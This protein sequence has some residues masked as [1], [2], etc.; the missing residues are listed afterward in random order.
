VVQGVLDAS[1]PMRPLFLLPLLALFAVAGCAADVDAEDDPVRAGEEP[2]VTERQLT[3]SELPDKTIALTFDDGPGPRTAEL[4]DWLASHGI[5]AAFFINGRNVP[6]RQKMVDEVI[7]KGH[8][9]GNHTQNHLDLTTLSRAKVIDEVEE[10]DADIKKVQPNGPWVLRAPFGAWNGMVTREV[11][12]TAMKKYVGS[13]FWDMGGELT[14][15]SAADWDCWGKGLT[16]ARCGALYLNEIHTRKHGIVL[17]HDSHSQTIDMVK[18]I[19]PQLI[20]Q[21]YKFAPLATVPSV[22]RAIAGKAGGAITN[23]GCESATL[24]QSVAENVCVQSASDKKWYRCVDGEWAAST[25]TDAKCTK[26]FPL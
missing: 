23:D 14:A 6:G 9:L 1:H 24:G 16:V 21:G 11:N 7:K 2:L 22:K 3:G 10:T 15:T 18:Q 12:A 8:L 5:K 4:A 19:V 13:V 25:A 26:R 20:A 17:M